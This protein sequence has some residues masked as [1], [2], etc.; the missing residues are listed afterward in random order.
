MNKKHRTRSDPSRDATQI[1]VARQDVINF[2]EE[3]KKNKKGLLTDDMIEYIQQSTLDYTISAKSL[4]ELAHNLRIRK[5]PIS[6]EILRQ[7]M[8]L[9]IN[10]ITELNAYIDQKVQPLIHTA[11]YD[12][13]FKGRNKLFFESMDHNSGYIM[14]LKLIESRESEELKD[15]FISLKDK[16]GYI[17]RFITD[18]G[19]GYPN[20]I[21][22]VFDDVEHQLCQLHAI[23]DVFKDMKEI[24]AL[25]KRKF[26]KIKELKSSLE[27][28]I[29]HLKNIQKSKSYYKNK[30][31]KLLNERDNL[32][33]HYGVIPYQKNIL[34]RFP[35]LRSIN[36]KINN[37]QCYLK[38][39]FNSENSAKTKKAEITE[40]LQNI[41]DEKDIIWSNYMICRKVLTKLIQYFKNQIT[42]KEDI[43]KIIDKLTQNHCKELGTNTIKFINNNPRLITFK[44]YLKD[45]E[46][47]IRLIT[48]NKIESFNGRF[49]KYKEIR[50]KWDNNYLSRGILEIIRLHF[51]FDRPI[52]NRG[53]NQSPLE[54]L[55]FN[56]QGKSLYEVIFNRLFPLNICLEPVEFQLPISGGVS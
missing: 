11:E 39:K 22:E 21:D 20:L 30:L 23:R 33:E 8:R 40:E 45:K 19:K 2:W 26:K 17:K 25:L 52:C 12:E 42:E 7:Y 28:K 44:S 43:I 18:L 1:Y 32:R 6:E 49:K 46:T 53:R 38:S 10:L 3:K 27:N 9:F 4:N 56:L 48:T 24:K 31:N 29:K 13:T 55:G 14:I 47:F 15:H 37:A 36:F 54:K 50:R 41:L 34:N 35:E 16:F 51:N 5:I